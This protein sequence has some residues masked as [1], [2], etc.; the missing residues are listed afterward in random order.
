MKRTHHFT[1]FMVKVMKEATYMI[2]GR[3]MR[4]NKM[5]M[6]GIAWVKVIQSRHQV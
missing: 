6:I 5:T 1:K 4:K 2:T 3:R